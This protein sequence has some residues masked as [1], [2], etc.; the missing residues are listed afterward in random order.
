MQECLVNSIQSDIMPNL[1]KDPQTGFLVLAKDG[2]KKRKYTCMC[3]DAH[4]VCFRQGE[5]NTA[6]FAHIPVHGQDGGTTY[7]SYPCVL[8]PQCGASAPTVSLRPGERLP[9]I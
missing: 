8:W 3:P 5:K 4:P 6:H 1:A 7:C 2:I 9:P